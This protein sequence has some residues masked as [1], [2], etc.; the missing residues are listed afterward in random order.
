MSLKWAV[1]LLLVLFSCGTKGTQRECLSV[2]DW[3]LQ[4]DSLSRAP[5][6]AISV[7]IES[8]DSVGFEN[9]VVQ[10]QDV[11]ESLE[12]LAKSAPCYTPDSLEPLLRHQLQFQDSL[13]R[14]WL[15]ALRLLMRANLSLAE[16]SSVTQVLELM[17]ASAEGQRQRRDQLRVR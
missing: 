3:Q 6:S 10:M 1:L 17:Q 14:T 12:S 11:F 9:G 5:M 16:R 4:W 15:P 7:A 8:K 2:S 13:V